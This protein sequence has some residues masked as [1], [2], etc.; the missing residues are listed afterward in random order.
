VA[1][2][3]LKAAEQWT[4]LTLRKIQMNNRAYNRNHN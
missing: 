2:A 3:A 4:R 1:G